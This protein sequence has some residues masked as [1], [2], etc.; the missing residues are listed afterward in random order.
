MISYKTLASLARLFAIREKIIHTTKIWTLEIGME[1][2][3][4]AERI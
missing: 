1:I 2:L 4:N 3:L